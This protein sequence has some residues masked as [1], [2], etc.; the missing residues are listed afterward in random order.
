MRTLNSA[1]L[2]AQ[3]RASASPY[4]QVQV[5][6]RIGNVVRLDWERLYSGGE[7]DY[8]H[9]TTVPGD[10]SL[11]RARVDPA[12]SQLLIQRVVDPGPGKDFSVWSSF[13][14]VSSSAGIALAGDGASVLLFYVAADN[15]TIKLA[16]SSNNGASFGSP[17]TVAT[18]SGPIGPLAGDLEGN[19]T[20]LLLYSAGAT[21][22]R[23]KRVSGVWGSPAAWTN[24]LA[25][26]TGLACCYA[27]DFN[28]VVTGTDSSDAA[29]VWTTIYGDGF[30][31][32]LD[33]WSNL[34]ELAHA[35]AGS[36][37]TFRAPFLDRADVPRLFFV[38]KFTG[39]QPYSRPL[40]THIS[41]ISDFA[42]NT[43]REP[44]PF[45]MSS[46]YGAAISHSSSHVWL[47][48]PAGVW[49]APFVGAS[50]DV[51][52]DVLELVEEIAPFDGRLRVVLRNDDGRYN[53]LGSAANAV[54]R[55]GA[56]INVSPGYLTSQGLR[57]STSPLFWIEGWQHDNSAGGGTLTLFARDG[58]SALRHWRA[59]RE[60]AWSAGQWNV[61]Q[62][63]SFVFSRAGLEYACLSNSSVLT[64]LHPSF[65]IHPGEDGL[66][67]V[68][69]LLAMVPDVVRV[70]GESASGIDPVA[71]QGADYAYGT[72]HTILEA[73]YRTGDV[74]LNRVQVFGQ[75]IML[76]AFDWP[77][78]NEIYDRL[79]QEQDLNLTSYDQ[80]Q[81]RAS[82]LLRKA[83]I[84]S[85]ADELLVPVNCGQ[86]LYDVVTV[87]DPAM[88]LVA[89]PRRVV[90]M[91]LRYS[92]RSA[93]PR[94]KMR[95]RLGAV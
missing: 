77:S 17:I 67:A 52:A 16:E 86:E 95:L 12:T 73:R 74:E 71:D 39:S 57:V 94:Y 63:L 23:V 47:S 50:L 90:G 5:K 34:A 30:N 8:F 88:G 59:R 36:N 18:A 38:E 83:A 53:D 6:D 33:T 13:T 78:I 24:S 92:R 48:T 76:D 27:I 42:S 46:E 4:M 7:S 3:K 14:T 45:D 51:S 64:S 69:R 75:G 44:V 35:D 11:V 41:P 26:V 22:Y 40:W 85:L 91:S 37:V 56:Q 61:F 89:A 28:V 43:W 29:G 31:Q 79:H 72:D 58:C 54:V 25:T 9:A 84:S 81:G 15:V 60:Y 68:R 49:R 19:G 55:R 62:L 93:D 65:A 10:G 80:A 21:V 20:A 87:T 66:T 32:P 82:A 70:V 1:L 2:A